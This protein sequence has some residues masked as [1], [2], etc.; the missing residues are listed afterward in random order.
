MEIR[1]ITFKTACEFIATYHRH[2]S[3]TVGCKFCIGLFDGEIMV[4]C[5]VC[6]RPVSR[7]L[8]DGLTCEINRL[9]TDGT[10][11]AC[12]MLYGACCRVAKAMGYKKIITYIL[13]SEPGTSLKAS[14]FKCEGEA[15]GGQW[16]GKRYEN[17]TRHPVPT[18]RKTRWVRNL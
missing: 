16:S 13:A 17:K 9:C 10:K 4:G 12:S 11:N 7:Y 15:G 2:H 6:G 18:E 3:P 14:N 5:A 8:D 1:P